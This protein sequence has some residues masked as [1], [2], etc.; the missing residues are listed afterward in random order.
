M[1]VPL[2]DHKTTHDSVVRSVRLVLLAALA[3]ATSV[4]AQIPPPNDDFANATVIGGLSGSTTGNNIDATAEPGE[5]LWTSIF[6]PGG[7]SVWWEWT[8]PQTGQFTFATEGSDY[9]TLL[10]VYTGNSVDTVAVVGENDDVNYPADA[11]SKVSFAAVAGTV[12][13]IAVDGYAGDQ[14]D[15]VLS[16]RSST[17]SGDF[18]F[19]SPLYIVSENESVFP[20]SGF[21]HAVPA[22]FTVTR[23]G[24]FSGRVLVDYTVTNTV[25]TNYIQT[26]LRSIS[27]TETNPADASV[28]SN[29]FNT[30]IV[31]T[32]R[33][34]NNE[35]GEFTYLPP[36][37]NF[38][39]SSL[40]NLSGSLSRVPP[41]FTND[42]STN[43]PAFSVPCF[44]TGYTSTNYIETNLFGFPAQV[45]VLYFCTNYTLTNI[46]PSAIA[47]AP[48]VT[49]FDYIPVSASL[50]FNDYQM[51]DDIFVSLRP[52]TTPGKF[53]TNLVVNKVLTARIDNVA[54]DP[55]ESQDLPPPTASITNS[56]MNVVNNYGMTYLAADDPSDARYWFR[57]RPGLTN[58]INIERATIR[59]NK[60]VNGQQVAHIS[61]LRYGASAAQS[62]SVNY[63]IDYLDPYNN[64]NNI[65]RSGRSGALPNRLNFF[66]PLQAGSDYA[67]PTPTLAEG[68]YGTPPDFQAVTGTLTFPPN[69]VRQ[70]I[71]VPIFDNQTVDF[72]KDFLLEIFVSPAAPPQ[73]Q[74]D[75]NPFIGFVRS[76]AVTILFNDVDGTV[77]PAGAVDRTHNPD[78][79][80]GTT[81][82]YNQH[83]GA[84]STVYAVRVQPDGR[85]VFG[86]D[87]TAYNTFPRNR[88]ARMLANGQIDTSFDPL[89]GADQFIS[90]M[91]LDPTNNIIIGG[92][93]N[94]Y[95][96]NIRNKIARI[97]TDGSLDTSFNPGVGANGTVWKVA[98][99]SDGKFLIGG[100]FSL[101]NQT[102]RS[103]VARLNSDGSLDFSFDPGAG[104]NGPI[105]DLAPQT[106]G[107][108]VI[109]GQFSTVSG[110]SRSCIARLNAD[111]SLDTSFNPRSGA[112]GDNP[113]VY[114]VSIQGNGVLVGG[115]FSAMYGVPRNNFARLNS[116]GSLDFTF[117]PGDGPDGSVYTIAQPGGAIMLSGSF[118]SV[119]QTRRVGMARLFSNGTVDTSFMD[120]AYNQFAGIITLY[121][122]P[123]A[124]P[125]TVILAT[126]SQPDGNVIIGGQFARIGGGTTRDDVRFRN[127]VARIVGGSTP[128][129]G[130]LEFVLGNDFADDIGGDHFIQMMRNNGNLGPASASV[131]P[132]TFA[133]GPGAAA[134]G[135]DFIFSPAYALPTYVS[136][137]NSGCATWQLK[138]GTFGQNQGFS[139]TVNPNCILG[140]TANDVWVTIQQ[141]T[142]RGDKYFNLQLSN[143]SDND[144]FLL[145]GEKIPLGVALGKSL[146]EV[147]IVDS[148]RDHGVFN[149]SAPTYVI[150][151]GSNAVISVTRSGGSDGSV[152]VIY[153]TSD[154]TA[155]NGVQYTGVT[156][157]LVFGQNVTNL[158]FPVATR[159]ENVAE[160]D[161]TVN[162]R[163]ITP[164]GGASLGTLTN[165]VLTI[166][167]NDCS[168]G[169]GK[170]DFSLDAYGANENA[171]FAYVT[172]NRHV[173]S[174][175]TLTVWFATRNGS[176][177]SGLNYL[178]QTNQLTW[179]SGDV[180][181]KVIAI[182]LLDDNIVEATNLTVSLLLTN[183][184][185][186]GVTNNALFLGTMNA[187]VLSITNTDSR[188]VLSFSLPSYDVDENGGF[189]T[190]PVVRTG[191]AA[192][193]ISVG[194]AASAAT[195][196]NNI[197]FNITNGTLAFGPGEIEK[198]FTVRIIDNNYPDVPRF[199]ALSLSGE[200]PS[201]TLTNPSV[202]QLN[203]IDDET[204]NVVAGS[205]DT[206]TDPMMGFNGNVLA[207]ALQPDGKILAG[208][209][210]TQ[211]NTL[212]RNRIARLNA[213]GSLDTTFSSVSSSAGANDLVLSIVPQTDQRILVGGRF[214]TI[215][216]INRFYLA[217]L[218]PSGFIDSTF[219]PGSGPDNSVFALAEIPPSGTGSDRQILVGGSFSSI[220]TLSGPYLA[221]LN[222]NGGVDGTYAATVN[223]S[224]F[225]IALQADGKAVVGGD[226]TLVNGVARNHIAR[227]N[228]D[229]TLDVSFSPTTG[230]NDSVRAVAIQLDGR[231]LIGGFF[232]N[233]N[234][235]ARS[236][237]A[238]LTTTGALDPSFN[239]GPGANDLV[240]S[241][242][243]QADT[244]IVLGGQF[245]ACNGV[246]RNRLTRLNPDGSVDPTINFG[247]GAD[248]FVAATL[249]QPDRKIV[250]GGGFTQYD[251]QSSE[252]IGRI[253]GGSTIGSGTFEFDAADYQVDE[254]S[255]N[256]I[257][258]VRRRGGTSGTATSTN[259][260]LSFATSDG[261]AHAGTN[262][263]SVQTSLIFPPGEILKTISVP[264]LRD[265]AITPD[266]TVNLT[267]SNPL[268]AVPGGPELGNQTLS[269][270]TILNDDSSISFSSGSYSAP[271]NAA[272]GQAVVPV[273]RSGSLRLPA[274][275]D[276]LTTNGTAIPGIDYLP[277]G[278]ITV[279]FP[280]GQ[281]SNVVFIPVLHETNAF[282]PS[283]VGLKLT[284]AQNALLFSP[285]TATLTILEV[286]NLPGSL[287]FAQTNVFVSEGAGSVTL[288]VLRT[289][290]HSGVV[291]VN[292]DT[293]PGTATPGLKYTTTSGILSFADGETNKTIT[294]PILQ[295]TNV[296]GN[297]AFTLAL[298]APS[299]GAAVV[300]ALAANIT[301]VDDD[302]GVAF[303]SPIYIANETDGSLIV[304]VNRVGTNG[305]TQ[306]SYLTSDGSARAG[307]NYS[308][309]S[310]TLTFNPGEFLKTFSIALM[311]D[312]RVTGDLFF[313]VNLTNPSPGA[314]IFANNPAT[315]DLL[316][317]DPGLAFTNANFTVLKS[318]TNALITVVRSNANSGL[319]SVGYAT[320]NGT[321]LAG[322]DYTAVNGT[323]IFSNGVI[324]QSFTVPIIA[325]GQVEGDRSFTVGLFNPSAP[326]QLLAP[327]TASVTITDDVSG[328]S[329]SAAAYSRS[330]NGVQAVISVVRTGFTNSL[331]AVDFN[332]SDGTGRA[333]VNYASTNGTLI[334]NP[335]ETVKIFSVFSID[336][337]L[338]TGDKTVLL[339]LLNR[340]GNATFVNPSDATLTF[341]ESDGSQ[342]VPSGT[343]L[344]TESGVANGVIDPGEQVTM[345][346]ALRNESGTNTANLISTLL[347][348]N[349]VTSP[350]AAQNYGA[351]VV[352][353]PA[354]SRPFTFTAN[355]TNGQ[356]LLATFELVDGRN[357]NRV[358]FPFV[359]G[360]S[361][362][363][364][365][366]S[367]PIVINDNSSATP[368]P[369]TIDVSGL[370]GSLK[371]ATAKLVNFTH[372]FPRDVDVLLVSPNG[373]ESFLMAK[374][375]GSIAVQNV[376]LTF[377]DDAATSLSNSTALTTSTNRPTSYALVPPAF[378]VPP[379]PAQVPT[380]PYYTNLSIFNG[381]TPNGVWSLFVFDDTVSHVG[382]ISNGWA[383]NLTTY[384][385]VAANADVALTMSGPAGSVIVLSNVT[386]T[387]AVTNYGPATASN[388]VV[389]DSLPGN[390]SY[391]GSTP[392]LGSATT[393]GA[394]LLTWSIGTLAKDAGTTLTLIVRPNVVG[395]VTNFAVAATTSSDVN[396]NDD[397]ALLVSSV[398]AQ[399]A[400]L[401]L[402]MTASPPNPAWANSPLTYFLTVSN[403]GPATAAGITIS[404][405]LPISFLFDS[406]STPYTL[407]GNA[408][409]L[410]LGSVGSGGQAVATV[411]VTPLLAGTFTNSA[412]CTSATTDPFKANN[413][414][415]AKTIVEALQ[416]SFVR[417]GQNLTISWPTNP[418]NLGLEYATNL[419]SPIFWAPVNSPVRVLSGAQWSATLGLTNAPRFFRVHAP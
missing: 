43:L 61:V 202:A 419:H 195:A 105:Y 160:G 242:S 190:I 158:T 318:A 405:T 128:G 30:N 385:P 170:T 50:I 402:S 303:S 178:G 153:A 159:N 391:V 301:I 258:T 163:I 168:K 325:N 119:N 247:L 100:E 418:P 95:N 254:I 283:T 312:P 74:I 40:T 221:R 237:I 384:T 305:V 180:Q 265:L 101:F 94:S 374:A 288:N 287:F 197:D 302:V 157:Q 161:T 188:G 140:Y 342:I 72:N 269:T 411:V 355:G 272:S 21:M 345:L 38:T 112:A 96:R 198:A 329:F 332:T 130:N 354:V 392:Q 389:S 137:Y 22:R 366:N 313:H 306:V 271:E 182:P 214:T 396:T 103:H 162:L 24:G 13:H 93:F 116:D 110:I 323:L 143:P 386:Y 127:N 29:Y 246:T 118:R 99:Q 5:L 69:N 44:R 393:N 84:N 39:N 340:V 52:S 415:S 212:N 80:S 60:D 117:D 240:S 334:F 307:T 387:L 167:D 309:S 222:D 295:E 260:S 231:V 63:R 410:S 328:L 192:G 75:V 98:L 12:Y 134:S 85:T 97:K 259:V 196:L 51:S 211:A 47:A 300:G 375:G 359:L 273:L 92:A 255:T 2:A 125:P 46:V 327:S 364:V 279:G 165:A 274:S 266:L 147:E 126:D 120:V 6:V 174:A 248:S 400:D 336:D 264:V 148:H 326:A 292:Y 58:I 55:L 166:V 304:T 250:F 368:Y 353:G 104:A 234:G 37:I 45:S 184:A 262:Y 232:T 41:A 191:G 27:V 401:S 135:L 403:A 129:P 351:V 257:I 9:D 154:G 276:F 291:T 203:I 111:G 256:A 383:L 414:A 79:D 4:Q 398:V 136:S 413:A 48:G 308:S 388:I 66:M 102:N 319:V 113:V 19:T 204:F 155:S 281:S 358:V 379:P 278:P 201:G 73:G 199:V 108:V 81:P 362:A 324:F 252:H 380:P 146:S 57:G 36:L 310:G 213:D 215:N 335:G 229:G 62:V 171:G 270:L 299:G 169:G 56:L 236:R 349:G 245:T 251:G 227:L 187:A 320:T 25:Y 32:Y 263:L 243:L 28:F 8:A 49:T 346:F 121:N 209:D 284:N 164:T 350:S 390:A 34:Q 239:P 228:T 280:T 14:G 371:K 218:T 244:R 356:P 382:G 141:S 53:G 122:S 142:N 156:N 107:K 18:K 347:V 369:S 83:P 138:D 26:E 132:Q 205:I 344:L 409:V 311:Y 381:P 235:V 186:N 20:Y 343:L 253:Y 321:A 360:Q 86:G 293:V 315:V 3:L 333:G 123:D 361:T 404:D 208:G 172:V 348:T 223:G 76:C 261:T 176:A 64:D 372:S 91:V 23:I 314:L 150:G 71:D 399:T 90:T 341:V 277:V 339:H 365:S 363:A 68:K 151:E 77:Q 206:T 267:L 131:I 33:Y 87:F 144:A 417:S 376:S 173:C 179:N 331:V 377:D 367:A 352:R 200:A 408:L 15:I 285:S 31:V 115:S 412:S 249:I 322:V 317:S 133:D 17:N 268:P 233:V 406:A 70:V 124:E 207:L 152:T 78:N 42:L 373:Q 294:I 183:A 7:S 330:E 370:G 65:F 82:P 109:G 230:A 378:P 297:T 316:D 296:E 1:G 275:I 286:D 88:I 185:V 67:V 395:A 35:Y 217:R 219:N 11:T 149:F 238:R 282:G 114:A 397:A 177:V 216:G 193:T 224:V 59:C 241:I 16:W 226:F 210:F 139:Q 225:A 357:T 407:N 337:S 194:F 416:M 10:G 189:A 289:N 54:L 175:G 298:S 290:G 220:N 181:P 338:V 145:G 106:D 89:D 394:G